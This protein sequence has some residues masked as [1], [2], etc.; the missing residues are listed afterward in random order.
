MSVAI[1]KRA[2]HGSCKTQGGQQTGKGEAKGEE[3][4][5]HHDKCLAVGCCLGP[6]T[7]FTALVGGSFGARK[8]QGS[9]TPDDD[10]QPA[11]VCSAM[12]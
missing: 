7:H 6:A 8:R 3:E 10:F 12:P 4:K 5:K 9:G 2:E 11:M 1:V